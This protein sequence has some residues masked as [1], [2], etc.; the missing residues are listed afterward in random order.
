MEQETS[1]F[2]VVTEGETITIETHAS[3]DVSLGGRRLEAMLKREGA[4]IFELRLDGKRRQVYLRKR[5]D[6]RYEVWIGCFVVNVTLSDERSR[7]L[8]R[9]SGQRSSVNPH[10]SVRAP[11]PGF[12]SSIRVRKGDTI[13]AG[14]P[15]MILEAMK[16]ENEIRSP[17]PGRIRE[18]LVKE[19]ATVEKDQTLVTLDPA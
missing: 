15:V 10:S 7:I 16:M 3:G 14:A 2:D 6:T 13:V 12:V 11:M 19:H 9:F 18:I 1:K 4:D 8:A 17:V 5:E